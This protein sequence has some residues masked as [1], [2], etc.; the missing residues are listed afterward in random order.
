MSSHL[1]LLEKTPTKLGD[2]P[3]MSPRKLTPQKLLFSPTKGS[4]I[5]APAYQRFQNLTDIGKSGLQLPFKYRYLLEMF[6]CCESVCAMFYNRKEIITFKK[7]KPAIQRMSRKNFTEDHLAQIFHLFPGSYKFD[8]VKMRNYGSLSKTDTY[9]LVIRPNIEEK[10]ATITSA[11]IDEDNLIKLG[12]NSI[13][14]S[15]V[16]MERLKKFHNILVELVKD[17]HEKFLT[18][19]NQPITLPR[20]KIKRWHPEFDLE[21]C[22]EIPKGDLPKPPTEEKFSSAKDILSTARNLFNCATPTERMMQ[23]YAETMN[24]SSTNEMISPSTSLNENETLLKGVPSSLLAKI[25]AKQTARAMA[26]M[27]RRPSQDIE[28]TKYLRL[29]DLTKHIRN[30]FVT[31]KK[32]VLPMEIVL[33]KLKNSYRGILTNAEFEDHM[34]LIEKECPSFISFPIIRNTKY[35]KILKDKD[36]NSVMEK[37][38]KI[39]QEKSQ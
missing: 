28:A 31:E 38:E 16:L 24:N 8:Q 33:E 14:N 5:K 27:T 7:L 11:V 4:P 17:E 36:I 34:K 9:Q 35:V 12:E 6:R 21:R 20:D 23:K 22:P 13:M 29:S 3:L 2:N 19:L 1:E 32:S 39:A 26:A 18:T 37:L 25:R 10:S 15:Q 30:V